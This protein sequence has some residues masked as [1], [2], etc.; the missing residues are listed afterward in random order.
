MSQGH[1]ASQAYSGNS[2]F[3][4]ANPSSYM[5]DDASSISG[6]TQSFR[7]SLPTYTRSSAESSKTHK[8]AKKSRKLARISQ[9]VAAVND[10]HHKISGLNSSSWALEMQHS[11][12]F[13]QRNLNSL[14]HCQEYPGTPVIS[15]LASEVSTTCPS[16]IDSVVSSAARAALNITT[17]STAAPSIFN[18]TAFNGLSLRER[19]APG[20]LHPSSPTY[21]EDFRMNIPSTSSID[22]DEHLFDDWM[23]DAMIIGNSDGSN[24]IDVPFYRLSFEWGLSGCCSSLAPAGCFSVCQSPKAQSEADALCGFQ[25]HS[26]GQNEAT[27]PSSSGFFSSLGGRICGAQKQDPSFE[28]DN[29]PSCNSN[30]QGNSTNII[31]PIIKMEQV[32]CEFGVLNPTPITSLQNQVTR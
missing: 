13:S 27:A 25:R 6:S 21:S 29:S 31:N 9:D 15:P 19:L 26:F 28:T 17:D 30:T 4:F 2:M 3:S 24:D 32:K 7:T 10:L 14:Q 5:F 1:N 16:P 8:C 18:R 22:L 23:D 20:P 11:L 12:E